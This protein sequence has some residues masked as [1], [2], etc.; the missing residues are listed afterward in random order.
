MAGG[1]KSYDL[2]YTPTWIVAAVCS[3]IIIISLF[4]ERLLHYLGKLMKKRSEKSLYEAVLKVKEELMLLGFI[5]FL[6]TVFQG[7]ISHI[8]IPRSY[9][10]HMLPCR[11]EDDRRPGDGDEPG[12]F[13]VMGKA[14]RHLLAD[15]DSEEHCEAEHGKVQLLSLAAI[16]QLHI[17]IFILA[18]T[19]V[20][21]SV[22]TICLGGLKIRQWKTWEDSIAKNNYNEEINNV[23]AEAKVTHVQNHA[24]IKDHYLDSSILS[25]L[26]SFLKQFHS[27]ISKSD[28]ITLRLGFIMTHCSGFPEFN[29]HRCMVRAYE[30]DFKKV[31]GI[32]WYLWGIVILFLLMNVEGWH[33]FFW[34]TLVPLVLLLAVGT[35]LEHVITQLARE[36]AEKHSAVEG[37]LV[38]Q[39]SDDHFWFNRPRLVLHLIHFIL[40]QNAFE[41]A[42]FFWLW[43]TYGFRSCIMGKVGYVI[44][45]LVFGVIIQVL[46]SFSTLPLYAIV[47]QMGSS[48]NKAIFGEHVQEN[49]S[50]WAQ[51]AR[52]KAVGPMSKPATPF[53]ASNTHA[54]NRSPDE[55]QLQEAP[56]VHSVPYNN[57]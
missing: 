42:F 38:V 50:G 40:F 11:R 23:N 57:P 37:D 44:P 12:H 10:H 55:I 46:C 45:R 31:V 43:L 24:F 19:H 26:H 13:Q 16:H 18:I 47:T 2:E 1:G 32:S 29:F 27:S 8:C 17:F 41:I 51:K 39:P 35:K 48:Y 34:I 30:A 14:M 21:L 7:R 5:S 28:Y 49:L 56:L 3:A 15:T 53:M 6:L 36:V 25:W 20:V 54:G 22:V 33:T 52:R 9:L 4:L